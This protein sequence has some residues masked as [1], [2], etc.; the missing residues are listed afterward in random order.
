MGLIP[1][2]TTLGNPPDFDTCSRDTF[3]TKCFLHG[4]F[5]EQEERLGFSD[6]SAEKQHAQRHFRTACILRIFRQMVDA[7]SALLER[8]LFHGDLYAHNIVV[9]ADSGANLF[10]S[11]G[12]GETLKNLK[13]CNSTIENSILIESIIESIEATLVDY[14]SATHLDSGVHAAAFAA[15]EKF[16]VRAL[17]YLLDD[18]V[19]AYLPACLGPTCLQGLIDLCCVE[20][21]QERAD[22]ATVSKKAAE[23]RAAK[24]FQL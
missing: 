24:E 8:G 21:V 12:L 2:A 5:A 7:A 17:G 19:K 9:R 15:M 20:S 4:F 11:D 14:G 13:A 16:E 18:L 3:N 10:E 22:M 23:L 1:D 6:F